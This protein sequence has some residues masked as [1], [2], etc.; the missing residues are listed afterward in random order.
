MKKLLSWVSRSTSGLLFQVTVNVANFQPLAPGSNSSKLSMLYSSGNLADF[1]NSLFFFAITLGSIF[2]V[3]KLLIAG[4]KY[5]MD[6][7]VSSKAAAKTT[8]GNVLFGLL[9]LLSVWIILNQI[10]PD[11]LKVNVVQ[12]IQSGGGY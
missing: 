6:D 7:M 9:V 11:I 8:I 3:V 4:Y 12:D 2:G 5:M 1:I 10:N